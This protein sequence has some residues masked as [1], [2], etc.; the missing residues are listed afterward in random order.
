[1]NTPQRL[2]SN[3]AL[4]YTSNII[5]KAGNVL[6]FIF[7]GRFYGPED[8]GIFN[9]G[10]TFLT[11]TLALSAWGLHELL[12]REAAPRRNQ[13][14]RYFVNFISLRLFLTLIGYAILL[15]ALR[16]L[17]P[18]SDSTSE[19]IIIIS[20]AVF[21]EAAFAIAHALFTAHEQLL[22]S[23]IA[24]FTNSGFKLVAG[25][26]LISQGQ[27]LEIVS[28]VIPIGS[29]L[30][31]MVFIPWL[32]LLFKV[33]RQVASARLSLG[34]TLSQ[35]RYT[36]G[37]ILI[38]FFSTIDFQ[39]DTFLISLLLSEEDIGWYGAAQTI[40]LGF[41]MVAP[42][43]RT[44]IY[45]LMS[46][47][48]QQDPAKLKVLYQKSTQYLLLLVL[49]IAVGITMLA[50]PIIMLI[51]GPSFAPSVPALQIMI[52]SIIFAYLAVP[53]ARLMLVHNRQHQAGIMTGL[54]MLINVLLNMTLIPRMGIIGAALARTTST[55]I[56]YL[57]IYGY[58]QR[59]LFKSSLLTLVRAPLVSV[60]LMAIVVWGLRDLPL[61]I[62]I[63]VGAL[64]YG[65]AAL[66]LGAISQEDRLYLKSF[67]SSEGRH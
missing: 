16:H 62:P 31:L 55:A 65:A 42:A 48:Y 12:V 51:Y 46:R 6:L 44:A 64:V 37:F 3:T 28:W 7:L 15:V 60:I 56:T 13:S 11:V 17:L 43:V 23:T 21:P 2:L 59:Y 25:Y 9:L 10:I 40:V 34:F 19:V 52:W 1:M 45:P 20:L 29:T 22:V 32:I 50:Q 24:S 36:P 8:A 53:N 26:W 38:G 41:W 18:Y 66:L 4:A 30:G 57:M 33:E 5:V 35:L 58:T 67:G 54:T 14:A 27:P 39:L 49:P 61:F 63:I 47:Y